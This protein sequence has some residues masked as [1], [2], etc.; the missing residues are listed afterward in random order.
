MGGEVGLREMASKGAIARI[1]GQDEGAFARGHSEL[2]KM[3]ETKNAR[4]RAEVDDLDQAL[5]QI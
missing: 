1:P 5:D 2:D 3:N 4:Q